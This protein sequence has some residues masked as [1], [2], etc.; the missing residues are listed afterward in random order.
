MKR[1]LFLAAM[2]SL[3]S[4]AFAQQQGKV[5]INTNNPTES[6]HVEGTARVT[7]L[8]AKGESI[9][10]GRYGNY[11]AGVPFTPTKMVV[12]NDNGVL[13]TAP[14]PTASGALS[15]SYKV[16]SG[17]SANSTWNVDL[18]NEPLYDIYVLKN[19]STTSNGYNT[20]ITLP[21]AP[22]EPGRARILRIMVIATQ[23]M[24]LQSVIINGLSNLNTNQLEGGKNTASV[25]IANGTFTKG[26]NTT[27]YEKVYTVIGIE[28]KWYLD[29]IVI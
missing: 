20:N 17:S 29:R 5:G 23:G 11:Q 9:S 16:Y 22:N 25:S 27:P 7:K 24:N 12:A 19:S 8:P 14:L 3:G 1:N 4:I 6:F 13:G 2:L 26:N 15:Y 28:G 10:T 21:P 18:T